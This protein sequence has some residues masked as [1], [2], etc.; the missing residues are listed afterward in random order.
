MHL[1]RI[2]NG[3]YVPEIAEGAEWVLEEPNSLVH[4]LYA[5]SLPTKLERK[6]YGR[7]VWYWWWT[8]DSE[9]V[10]YTPSIVLKEALKQPPLDSTR[11]GYDPGFYN[12]VMHEEEPRLVPLFDC[13]Q[14]GAF[15]MLEVDLAESIQ[16]VYDQLKEMVPRHPFPGIVFRSMSDPTKSAEVHAK[17]FEE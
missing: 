11:L 8:F 16:D 7:K 4:R 17:H 6:W 5:D 14:L 12:L 3:Y 9:W 10:E 13:V 2:E 1:F 15:Q